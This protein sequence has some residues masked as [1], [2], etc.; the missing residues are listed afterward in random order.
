MVKIWQDGVLPLRS[1][2]S[3]FQHGVHANL[4]FTSA[5]SDA[6]RAA[7]LSDTKDSENL[8]L[9]ASDITA[10]FG[11]LDSTFSRCLPGYFNTGE[12]RRICDQ[13]TSNVTRLRCI[14]SER[15]LR[16]GG[17]A[18]DFWPSCLELS[19]RGSADEISTIP[20]LMS[21]PSFSHHC[22]LFPKI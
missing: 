14:S 3:S 10:F 21:R 15:D 22:R 19:W 18:C 16:V 6:I 17:D 11:G 5:A 4:D 12:D 2:N 9:S 20:F 13:L 7:D 1:F 8:T